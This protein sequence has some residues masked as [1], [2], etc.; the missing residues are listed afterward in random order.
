MGGA[1]VAIWFLLVDLVKADPFF[2]PARLGE[3][4]GRVFGITPMATSEAGA[5]IG[6]TIIHFVGF[7]IIATVA[8]AIVHA[9]YRQPAI[10][11]GVFLV[12]IVSEVLI[13]GYIALLHA[14]ELLAHLTWLLI[15]VGNLIGAVVIGW[16]LWRDHPGLT[17][18]F[19]SAL[20]GRT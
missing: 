2:T 3:A 1:A 20:G 17:A 14:T 19:D 8:A 18:G 15:A 9:A 12:F 6:Y 13:Y 5:I 16:K 10:L 7:V 4:T 11:A